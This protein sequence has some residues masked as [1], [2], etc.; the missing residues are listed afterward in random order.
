[1]FGPLGILVGIVV[2]CDRTRRFIIAEGTFGSHQETTIAVRFPS[3][4]IGGCGRATRKE[5]AFH[6]RQSVGIR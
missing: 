2:G 3:K 1:M 4:V 5:A 6:F